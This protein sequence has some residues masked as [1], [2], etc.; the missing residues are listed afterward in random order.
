MSEFDMTPRQ[1]FKSFRRL[2]MQT[3]DVFENFDCQEDYNTIC[4]EWI[5][6]IGTLV[7]ELDNAAQTE[8]VADLIDNG[9]GIG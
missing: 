6:K 9:F 2:L 5:R 4:R 3:R 7:D 1:E 8:Q